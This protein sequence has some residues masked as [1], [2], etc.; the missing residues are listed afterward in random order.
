MLCQKC[1]KRLIEPHARLY[2]Q[3]QRNEPFPGV[4]DLCV[5][6]RHRDGTR[7]T[8][9][10]LKANGGEGV[11]ILIKKPVVAHV[12]RSP[13]RLSGVV[14]MWTESATSCKQMEVSCPTPASSP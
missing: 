8:S 9:P 3:L 4:L 7:C 1:S 6:C 11:L 2:R 5:D 14:Q 13:R 12:C 10:D